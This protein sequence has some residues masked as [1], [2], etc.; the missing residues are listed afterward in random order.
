MHYAKM[1]A[2]IICIAMAASCCLWADGEKVATWKGTA[3]DRNWNVPSNWAEGVVPGRYTTKD[4]D[5]NTV[6][7]GEYG[8]TARFSRSDAQWIL[9][10][11]YP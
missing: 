7:N 6:T 4:A 8:W 5:N 11:S 3:S 9:L 10:L 1:K 2:T